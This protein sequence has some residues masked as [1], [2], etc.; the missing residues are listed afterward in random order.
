M[1]LMR[2][3]EAR[4][5]FLRQ[6]LALCERVD[7]LALPTAQVWPFAIGDNCMVIGVEC[8]QRSPVTRPRMLWDCSKEEPPWVG[9]F[10][11]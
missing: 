3:N 7:V 6:L 4:S 2:T 1:E 10:G 5:T 9:T 11:R 8:A